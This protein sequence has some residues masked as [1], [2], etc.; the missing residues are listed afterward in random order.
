MTIAP[1]NV[2]IMPHATTSRKKPLTRRHN[3]ED[4]EDVRNT[5]VN[6][7]DDDVSDDD[8]PRA[9]RKVKKEKKA[10]GKQRAE[11][12]EQDED[13][14]AGEEYDDDEDDRID[15]SN[16]PDQ[17]LR[18]SDM[19]KLNGMAEDWRNMRAQIGQRADIYRDVAA[20]MAEAGEA[21]IETSEVS[22][23]SAFVCLSL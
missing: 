7:N 1:F 12:E 3:S 17:P 19:H 2:T 6:G 9:S 20:A 11:P 5:Q 15:V 13:A 14:A 10:N 21:S 4:I 8:R 16:L 18:R 23:L 22:I